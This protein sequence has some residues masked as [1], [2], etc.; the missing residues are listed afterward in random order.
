MYDVHGLKNSTRVVYEELCRLLAEKRKV[1][2][3]A[4]E[5]ATGYTRSTVANAIGLLERGGYIE[6]ERTGAGYGATYTVVHEEEIVQGIAKSLWNIFTMSSSERWERFLQ[7]LVAKRI[8]DDAQKLKQSAKRATDD[9]QARVH[10]F[11]DQTQA[12]SL[13]AVWPLDEAADIQ[14]R[15]DALL[16]ETEI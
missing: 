3:T 9:I 16:K 6:I 7:A 13:T 4:L 1:S 15:L 5:D 8:Y 10:E 14:N 12:D 11:L 2:Y